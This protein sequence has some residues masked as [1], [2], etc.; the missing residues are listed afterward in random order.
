MTEFRNWVYRLS[1][2]SHSS[3]KYG[4]C[5]ICRKHCSEVFMQGEQREVVL[6]D[7]DPPDV[8]ATHPD[9]IDHT[10]Y[11]CRPHAF[12]HEACLIGIR[13]SPRADDPTHG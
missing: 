11:G 3:A 8:L 1:S 10:F 2:T 4:V 6:D 7:N 12:G 13:K 9:R 5:E